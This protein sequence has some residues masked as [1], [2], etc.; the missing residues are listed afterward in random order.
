MIDPYV[1]MAMP[2]NF[3]LSSNLYFV[4][5]KYPVF[6]MAMPLDFSDVCHTMYIVTRFFN[7]LTILYIYMYIYLSH[8]YDK[9]ICNDFLSVNKISVCLSVTVFT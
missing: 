2:F 8:F 4:L 9:E 6:I 7:K 1:I 3:I 5:S